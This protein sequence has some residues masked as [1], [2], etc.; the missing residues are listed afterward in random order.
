MCAQHDSRDTPRGENGSC[1]ESLTRSAFN[2]WVSW[3]FTGVNKST[4][5]LNKFPFTWVTI[6]P[7][8]CSLYLT[9]KEET[10]SILETS[11][12]RITSWPEKNFWVDLTELNHRI[13][14]YSFSFSSWVPPIQIEFQLD[15][16]ERN[17]VTLLRTDLPCWF[18]KKEKLIR[19]N[20]LKTYISTHIS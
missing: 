18:K 11:K 16:F 10:L 14:L 7:H 9:T 6:R 15:A 19:V 17:Y 8:L 2:R 20:L 13:F 3:V 12:K 4:L 1:Q 5:A